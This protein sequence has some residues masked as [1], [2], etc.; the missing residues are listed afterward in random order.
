MSE[1]GFLGLA[2]R[3]P[4]ATVRAAMVLFRDLVSAD[5]EWIDS[6]KKRFGWWAASIRL[7]TLALTAAS[8]VVLGLPFIPERASWALPIVALVT[9]LGG[10]EAFFNWRS[11]WLLM[12]ESKYRMN[13]LRDDMDYYL[14]TTPE[15]EV[16]KAQLD[17]FYAEQRDIWADVS[18]RW[19]EFRKLD[20]PPQVGP[21]SHQRET[22]P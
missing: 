4:V 21:T 13:R 1:K 2:G 6:R 8:T 19:I 20:R 11:R 7:V 18:R 5:M 9:A 12:E 17:E 22:S 14:V 16:S 15:T 10:L 3:E